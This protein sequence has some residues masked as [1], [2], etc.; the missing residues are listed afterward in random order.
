MVGLGPINI[1][2][3]AAGGMGITVD[4]DP[5]PLI[6]V[7][8]FNKLGLDIRSFREPLKRSIQQVVAPSLQKNFDV[9]GRPDNWV[10]LAVGTIT[11]K[12]R[13]GMNS[14]SARIPLFRYAKLYKQAGQLNLWK[15]DGLEGTAIAQLPENLFYGRIHQEGANE[16]G[17]GSVSRHKSRATGKYVEIAHGVQGFVPQRMWAV[18]QDE[19][20]DGIEEVFDAWVQERLLLAGFV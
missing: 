1:S 20:V 6:L 17:I 13:I 18:I 8:Q 11:Q 7:A 15:I 19:D 9:E 3:R 12:A 4:M 5:S 2:G 16:D 14:T 10:P